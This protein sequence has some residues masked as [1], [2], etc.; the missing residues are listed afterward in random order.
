[1]IS[2][3]KYSYQISQHE[4]AVAILNL[5]VEAM[6]RLD[7]VEETLQRFDAAGAWDP[8]RL[9]NDRSNIEHNVDLYKRVISR[10]S[11]YYTNHTSKIC[12]EITT[13]QLYDEKIHSLPP[14]FGD[15]EKQA[16]T[17]NNYVEPLNFDDE[18]TRTAIRACNQ[19]P[20]Y[21]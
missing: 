11:R 15:V 14:V 7:L 3:H 9:M 18:P 13:I 12:Q 21:Y 10:L 16:H 19:A 4:K 20:G 6:K 5:K 8:I 17:R 2:T 1:M